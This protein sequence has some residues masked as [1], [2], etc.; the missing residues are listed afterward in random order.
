MLLNILLLTILSRSITHVKCDSSLLETS[1]FDDDKED[2]QLPAVVGSVAPEKI[3]LT[4]AA[5]NPWMDNLRSLI[6][7]EE[8]KKSE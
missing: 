1:L 2:Q 7:K 4:A 8:K 6:A 5:F 3:K